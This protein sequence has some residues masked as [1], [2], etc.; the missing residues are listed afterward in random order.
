MKCRTYY[1]NSGITYFEGEKFQQAESAI[2][3][4]AKLMSEATEFYVDEMALIANGNVRNAIDL[5]QQLTD[6][7]DQLYQDKYSQAQVASNDV[8]EISDFVL[9]LIPIAAL[10]AVIVSIIVALVFTKQL[11]SPILQ[12][13]NRIVEIKETSNITLRIDTDCQPSEL[14]KIGDSLNDLLTSFQQAMCE[15]SDA[16][17]ELTNESKS[18]SELTSKTQ[19]IID[20]QHQESDLVATAATQMSTTVQEM[21]KSASETS[22]SVRE[23]TKTTDSGLQTV[24]NNIRSVNELESRPK[25]PSHAS[26]NCSRLPPSEWKKTFRQGSIPST[27]TWSP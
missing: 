3:Q 19:K 10:F 14:K 18:T 2:D 23:A 9:V 27:G 5:I 17:E 1:L 12:F 15:V 26:Q 8:S 20:S 13:C 7:I 6:E 11:T 4:Y 25:A 22:R 16:A 21:A 24:G